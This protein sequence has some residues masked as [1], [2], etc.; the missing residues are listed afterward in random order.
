[1][2]REEGILTLEASITLT[3]YLFFMMFLVNV[4]QIYRAQNYMAHGLMQT[5]QMLA[6]SSYEYALDEKGRGTLTLGD[7]ANAGAELFGQLFG[8]TGA[9]DIKSAWKAEKYWEAAQTAFVYCAGKNKTETE[10]SLKQCG[11]NGMAAIDFSKTCCKDD[12]LCLRVQYQVDLPFNVFG[13]DHI[14]MHQ[15]IVCGLW[16]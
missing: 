8:L 4:G 13:Y 7:L 6:F 12:D 16:E 1:M 15:Q 3:I 14:D 10:K 11:I 9:S 2:K 5:G